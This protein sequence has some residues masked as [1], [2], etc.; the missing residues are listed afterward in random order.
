MPWGEI[1]HPLASLGGAWSRTKPGLSS[2]TCGFLVNISLK[3]LGENLS[4]SQ[5]LFNRGWG[6]EVVQTLFISKLVTGRTVG[7]DV[8]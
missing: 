2:G 5:W 8:H 4:F 7:C 1:V 6:R 3:R